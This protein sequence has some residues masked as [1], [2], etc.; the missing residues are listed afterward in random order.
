MS[1][2][3]ANVSVRLRALISR[4][5]SGGCTP[6]EE[7][8]WFPVAPTVT[9]LPPV[10]AETINPETV[11]ANSAMLPEDFDL[12]DPDIC[13]LFTSILSE[14]NDPVYSREL[15]VESL[16]LPFNETIVRTALLRTYLNLNRYY[17]S[18]KPR[19]ADVPL[20]GR[21]KST[22]NRLYKFKCESRQYVATL[23][24]ARFYID[25]KIVGALG[26]L[27][28]TRIDAPIRPIKF[29]AEPLSL[30]WAG[31]PA[32]VGSPGTF[33]YGWASTTNTGTG[34]NPINISYRRNVNYQ[35]YSAATLSANGARSGAFFI[36]LRWFVTNAVPSTYSILGFN[37]YL[38]H[39]TATSLS[40]TPTIKAGESKVQVYSSSSTT[41]FTQAESLGVLQIDFSQYF[42]WDGTSS[43]IVE[44][45]TSQNQTTYGNYGS[46][47]N[48]TDG[49][50]ARRYTLSDSTG[51]SCGTTASTTGT[52][53]VAIQMD[54][55]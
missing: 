37:M 33:S 38:W 29:F 22:S 24:D 15:E 50:T 55:V 16:V 53:S 28:I 49:I 47:R 8:I 25:H 31:F 43:I 17:Y 14:S 46:L 19:Q 9:T 3:S 30:T 41:E 4:S 1:L 44:T 7:E 39:T 13:A 6:P 32:V 27:V 2:T 12:D 48:I 52:G 21:V 10:P 42:R 51:S 54:Y 18:L 35:L 5:A 34:N 20:I 23:E 26:S 40:S 36:N 45:C 11:P